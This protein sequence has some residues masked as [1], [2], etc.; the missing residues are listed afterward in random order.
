MLVNRCD[1]SGGRSGSG[2]S[3]IAL[4]PS[5]DDETGGVDDG[6]YESFATCDYL[7]EMKDASSRSSARRG[8]RPV[9]IVEANNGMRPLLC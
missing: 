2:G 6:T 4:L 1:G 5:C 3:R 7:M 9:D 8:S